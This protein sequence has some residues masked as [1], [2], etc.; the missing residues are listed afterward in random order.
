M[1]FKKMAIIGF[2]ALVGTAFF[3]FSP[4]AFPMIKA[5]IWG[6]SMTLL[7]NLAYGYISQI[8]KKP[9]RTATPNPLMHGKKTVVKKNKGDI[10]ANILRKSFTDQA[11]KKGFRKP[12]P[13]PRTPTPLQQ[14]STQE[15]TMQNGAQRKR[16]R[17]EPTFKL[18]GTAFQPVSTSTPV[19]MVDP[20]APSAAV[21]IPV[22]GTHDSFEPS[23]P[24]PSLLPGENESPP[25]SGIISVED[26]IRANIDGE[27]PNSSTYSLRSTT[28]VSIP[29]HVQSAE[30]F[31][32]QQPYGKNYTPS[33][34]AFKKT[35][36]TFIPDTDSA[37]HSSS[38]TQLGK[39]TFFPSNT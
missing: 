36:S 5:I 19:P 18:K 9:T 10:E 32:A 38:N 27:Y 23:A 22:P 31:I 15:N 2:C 30:E 21:A 12:E 4:I 14:L 16:K 34:S 33:H 26:Y 25:S 11:P 24:D 28:F 35:R 6:S 7:G 13:R 20:F 1:T 39:S 17:E 29:T 8:P 37:T 3:S